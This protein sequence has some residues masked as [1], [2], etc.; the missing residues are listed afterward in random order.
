MDLKKR[1]A[2]YR[3]QIRALK[4]ENK[5]LKHLLKKTSEYSDKLLK[6]KED[7][8]N[9]FTYLFKYNPIG[10]IIIDKNYNIIDANESF[11]K[12]M[13]LN[14]ADLLNK[15]ITKFCTSSS[16]QWIN[17]AFNKVYIDKINIKTNTG[18][19]K[20]LSRTS[21][22]LQIDENDFIIIAAFID[23]TKEEEIKHNLIVARDKAEKTSLMKS[24]F[25]AN[26]S[27][28][29]RTPLNAIIGFGQLLENTELTEEQREY[30]DAIKTA[31]NHMLSIVNDI[32]YLSKLDYGNISIQNEDFLLDEIF[33]TIFELTR[34]KIEKDIE[35][36]LDLTDINSS[37]LLNG[38]K[39]KLIQ[40][41]IN[42]V[43]NAIKFTNKGFIKIKVNI[44]NSGNKP[45][46]K[47]EII[48]TGIG[49]PQKDI[50]RIFEIFE[51]VENPLTKKYEG[52]GLGI[53]IANRLI[54]KLGGK[55]TVKSKVGEGS[56]FSFTIP[57][58][59]VKET[60]FEKIN[61]N[62]II[63]DKNRV[64]E[65]ITDIF[66]KIGIKPFIV[67]SEAELEN[68]ILQ[69]N[70]DFIFFNTAI[71]I[72]IIINLR[73]I[74]SSLKIFYMTYHLSE[75][76]KLFADNYDKI[77]TKPFT[78]NSLLKILNKSIM[79][80]NKTAE[81]N[82]TARF[83][84]LKVI[85]AEDNRFNQILI[86][87]ILEK[88]NIYPD[89]AENGKEVIKKV[90]EN[91]YDLIFMDIKMPELD[92]ISAAKIIK[93][94]NKE[95]PIIAVSAFSENET[96]T[97]GETRVFDSF[98]NKPYKIEEIENVLN[99]FSSNKNTSKPLIDKKKFFTR[100]EEEIK[101][102][103]GNIDKNTVELIKKEINNELRDLIIKLNIAVKSSNLNDTERYAHSIKGIT[104]GFKIK[105]LSDISETAKSIELSIKNKLRND[106]NLSE[107]QKLFK[108]LKEKIDSFLKKY[109]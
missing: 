90:K 102:I 32:L 46:F 88:F 63:F 106:I 57:L 8:L 96:F 30:L 33:T 47:F 11:E 74:K 75:E 31:G 107:V 21:V 17:Q 48:D 103:Y 93:E 69:N 85:V 61:R 36:F 78:P 91:Q 54:E 76:E 4:E 12:L 58:K 34:S 94:F 14:K 56:N 43:G 10:I 20:T 38:D 50:K 104:R 1:T 64:D 65:S 35:L 109:F 2:Q 92:G 55:L 70:I 44:I 66:Q 81:H 39:L 83:S 42:L 95:I 79:I 108:I 71:P 45:K 13:K 77:I 3:K 100:F 53:T 5:I 87:R 80:K 68:T 41:F 37:F 59:I 25:V 15:P 23:I 52:T 101:K 73:N 6:E 105:V 51:Q 84:K 7:N 89:M 60:D 62:A 9:R 26:M 24:N 67:S 29:M 28:E 97:K 82:N 86:N 98:I 40:I 18:E 19:E 16:R 99:I 22:K 27:H 49:I 72:E